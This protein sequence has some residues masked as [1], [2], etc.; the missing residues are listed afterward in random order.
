MAETPIWGYQL[1]DWIDIGEEG[2]PNWIEVTNL[3]SWEF[4]DDQTTYDPSYIDVKISPSFVLGS[5][6]SID[7]E[8]DAYLGNTLDEWIIEHEDDTSIPVKIARVRTWEG[9]PTAHPA[10]SAAFALTPQQL[11][12]NS[13][14][15]PLKLKGTVSKTGDWETGTFNVSEP[16]FTSGSE[17]MAMSAAAKTVAAKAAD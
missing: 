13:S 4:S 5:K 1:Q 17:P 3:L 12:K 8:K 6:A 14:G 15:E 10:K 7:Y 9:S 2:T 16:A 11:D